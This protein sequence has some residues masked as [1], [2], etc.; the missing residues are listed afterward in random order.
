MALALNNQKKSWYAIKQRN[1]TN[2]TNQ[3]SNSHLPIINL[4]SIYVIRSSNSCVFTND[5]YD[6]KPYLAKSRG[7]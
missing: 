7:T 5:I 4:T 3:S 1:Q 6:W 2:Q